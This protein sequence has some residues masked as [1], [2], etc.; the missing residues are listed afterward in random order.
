MVGVEMMS[1]STV[2]SQKCMLRCLG[3]CKCVSIELC[4]GKI[5]KTV[6]YFFY[7]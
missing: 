3:F 7:F 2:N 5:S 6:Y 1:I 4:T